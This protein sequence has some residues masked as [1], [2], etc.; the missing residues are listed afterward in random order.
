MDAVLKQFRDRLVDEALKE[1]EELR[2]LAIYQGD[3][4]PQTRQQIDRVLRVIQSATK[5]CQ[6]YE[7]SRTNDFTE[8]RLLSVGIPRVAGALGS[9]DDVS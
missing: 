5:V 4:K 6:A 3:N 7:H 8:H 2:G 9:G 1:I